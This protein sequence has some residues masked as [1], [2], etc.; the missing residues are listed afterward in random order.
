[1]GGVETRKDND[2]SYNLVTSLE[3]LHTLLI[4][5]LLLEKEGVGGFEEKWEVDGR[6][7]EERREEGIG[8]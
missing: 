3:T 7:F 1:M 2:F 4:L 6:D 5:K 8:N